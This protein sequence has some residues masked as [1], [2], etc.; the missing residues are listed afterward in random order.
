MCCKLRS[1]PGQV[2]FD[3]VTGTTSGEGA[4]GFVGTLILGGDSDLTG[5]AAIAPCIVDTGVL[6]TGI[7]AQRFGP[8]AAH[9]DEL[10]QKFARRVKLDPAN[11]L[12]AHRSLSVDE[13]ISQLRKGSIRREFPGEFLDLTVEEALLGGNSTVRELLTSG[14]MRNDRFGVV[15]LPCPPCRVGRGCRCDTIQRLSLRVPRARLRFSLRNGGRC[16]ALTGDHL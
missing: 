10:A 1:D 7:S 13:F 14:D 3:A 4:A 16:W 15:Q 11:P 2:G 9:K 8:G 12:V 6:P 5:C